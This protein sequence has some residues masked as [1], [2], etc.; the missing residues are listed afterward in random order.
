M[1]IVDLVKDKDDFP[2]IIMEKCNQSLL[3]IIRKNEEQ[4]ITEKQVLGVLA[5]VCLSLY[6]IHPKKKVH[7]DLK[8]A[9]ILLMYIGT[10]EAFIITDFGKS[11]KPESGSA[12]TV[13]D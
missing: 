11:F 4:P 6:H 13:K 2:C 3:D 9:N 5:V 12:T 7:H 1:G 10:Y 8:P